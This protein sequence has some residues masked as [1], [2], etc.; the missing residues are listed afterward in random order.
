MPRCRRPW[1][2]LGAYVRGLAIVGFVDALFIGIGL[3][4]VGAPLVLPLSVLVFF[5]AFF[6]IVGAFLTG[7]LAVSVAFVNGGLTDALIVSPSSSGCSRWRG[8][9][10]I[11]SSSGGRSRCIRW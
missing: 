11:R 3:L 10:S 5:G 2:T 1:G 6:P 8:T 7:L 4:L 9:C